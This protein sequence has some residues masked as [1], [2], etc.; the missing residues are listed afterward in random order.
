MSAATPNSLHVARTKLLDRWYHDRRDTWAPL[1]PPRRAAAAAAIA[2]SNLLS[3][4][5]LAPALTASQL[6]PQPPPRYSFLMVRESRQDVLFGHHVTTVM[7]ER[8]H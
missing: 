8:C 4:S 3:L 1:N 7:S 2:V 6:P 5:S